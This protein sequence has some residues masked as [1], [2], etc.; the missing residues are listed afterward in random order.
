ERAFTSFGDGHGVWETGGGALPFYARNFVDVRQWAAPIQP[1]QLMPTVRDLQRKGFQTAPSTESIRRTLSVTPD[2]IQSYGLDLSR[3][4][5]PAGTGLIWAAVKR[6][7]P[8]ARSRPFGGDND[9]TASVVQ[10][11]NLGISVKDSPQNT[12]VFVTRLDTGAPVSDADVS[13]IRLDN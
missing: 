5:S 6:G 9:T 3:A 11:T 4:L 1:D 13:I 12:L 10:V 2:T 8:I 7:T